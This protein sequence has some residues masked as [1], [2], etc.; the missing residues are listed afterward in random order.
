MNT[1]RVTDTRKEGDMCQTC[2]CGKK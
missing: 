1:S 2:G